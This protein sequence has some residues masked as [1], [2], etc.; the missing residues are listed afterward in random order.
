MP[1]YVPGTPTTLSGMNATALRRIVWEK[2]LRDD[3]V[4]PSV[5][6]AIPAEFKITEG[7]I[8]IMKPGMMLDV[9]NVG[10]NNGQSVR[11]ALSTPLRKRPKY[12]P[13]ELML[14][15]EDESDL[16]WTELYYNEIKK[17]IKFKKWGYDFNDT[18]YLNW[19][20]SYGPKITNF[21]AE[22]YDTRCQEALL[23][24]YAEE[25][26]ATP[27]SKGQQFNKNWFIPNLDDSNFPAWDLTALTRTDGA[28][29][30]D[31]YYSSRTYSGAATFVENIATALLQA[32]G[33]GSTSNAVLNVD[34][35]AYLSTWIFDQ[36]IVDPV[37][38]DGVPS[39]VLKIP[40]RVHG[41]LKNPNNTGSLAAYWQNVADYIDKDRMKIPG[42]IGRL[43][44][45][46]VVVVDPRSPTLTVDGD[47]GSYTL[48]PGFVQPGN[49]DDRN[50]QAW[51]NTSGATN[52][53]FDMCTVM[54]ANCLAKFT[55]DP[56]VTNLAESTEY[57]Q[58]QGRGAYLG[59]GL[60]IP[61][62]DKD[63]AGQLDG[64]STT[65]IQRGS[66]LVPMSRRAIASIV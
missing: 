65:Q 31:E 51:S 6:N 33:T 56:L 21:M 63:A 5:F 44:D 54:G 36:H 53:V 38:I 34:N 16:L 48:Q 45:C 2:K 3:S 1:N 32:S 59:E 14:G 40:L 35:L 19:V 22:N 8:E 37:M 60:Q 18:A 66:C 50:N 13:D 4:R 17:A 49:N 57:G 55:H 29:D 15:N 10:R 43:F 46:L 12:G 64:A 41:W 58:I 30:A 47:V 26:S 39:V 28:A 27:V 9:T 11:L 62:F 42:E 24:T 7:Q 23:L 52:Y 25:L 20:E 61:A